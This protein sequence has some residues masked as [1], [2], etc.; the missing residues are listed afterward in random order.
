MSG[1]APGIEP[2]DGW[3]SKPISQKQ[4]EYLH[5]LSCAMFA[6]MS[7]GEAHDMIARMLE[8]QKARRPTDQRRRLPDKRRRSRGNQTSYDRD[9]LEDNK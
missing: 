6:M 2:N 5:D 4:A 1:I 7:R 3:R 9:T 8:S